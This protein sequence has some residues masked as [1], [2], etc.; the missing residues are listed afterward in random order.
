VKWAGIKLGYKLKPWL[1]YSPAEWSSITHLFTSFFVLLSD[2]HE[3]NPFFFT[4][5]IDDM[6]ESC[7]LHLEKYSDDC[8]KQCGVRPW[9]SCNTTTYGGKNICSHSNIIF[10][11]AL[12]VPR[13]TLVAGDPC[14]MAKG[15][16]LGKAVKQHRI[17]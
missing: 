13:G 6:F 17:Y 8:Y 3:N 10:R 2:L 12:L 4:N 5:G 15:P 16:D 11:W 14:R 1:C 7:V 9:T